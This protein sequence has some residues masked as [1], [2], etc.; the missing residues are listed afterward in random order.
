MTP[1]RIAAVV[2]RWARFYTRRLP[3]HEAERRVEELAADVHAHIAHERARR[4]G[5]QRIAASI[6]ARMVRGMGADI[7]WRHDRTRR[8]RTEETTMTPTRRSVTRVALITAGLL[9]IP[10]LLMLVSDGADWGVFDFVFA[11]LI[12]F[13]AGLLIE[14]TLVSRGLAGYAIAVLGSALGVAAMIAGE[15]DD[16]PGLVGLGLLLVVGM[17]ALTIRSVVRAR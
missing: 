13:A 3:D 16:A 17:V 6:A 11:G 8:H 10:L 14:L 12:I 5:D 4:T 2:E 7:A 9:L 15:R 1:E